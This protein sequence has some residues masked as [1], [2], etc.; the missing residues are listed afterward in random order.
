MQA[1][2]NLTFMP[3][4]ISAAAGKV[5]QWTNMGSTQHTITFGGASASCLSDSLLQAG[6]TWSVRFTQP[7][8][9]MYTCQIHPQMTG[10]IT[11]Q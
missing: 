8:T 11:V 3:Q 2:D 1:T 5:V 9:Y 6:S 7:G 4:S 10:T